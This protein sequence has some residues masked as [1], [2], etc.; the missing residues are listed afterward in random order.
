MSAQHQ[1]FNKLFDAP[2]ASGR[3]EKSAVRTCATKD[4]DRRP[5]KGSRYCGCCKD[6]RTPD[7]SGR[8]R[9]VIAGAD[10]ILPFAPALER[11]HSSGP[12]PF[13]HQGDCGVRDVKQN[14]ARGIPK[15]RDAR[16]QRG[17]AWHR[18]P[19]RRTAPHSVN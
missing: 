5:A 1:E 14:R 10:E 9:V 6:D 3:A 2:E 19:S 13:M 4:C 7:P 18:D 15:P 12:V 16:H 11:N 8:V 17:T